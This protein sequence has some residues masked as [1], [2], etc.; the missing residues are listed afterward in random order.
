MKRGN[1]KEVLRDFQELS[2]LPGQHIPPI[3]LNNIQQAVKDSQNHNLPEEIKKQ[4]P[5]YK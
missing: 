1:K 3:D 2:Y 5:N 4:Y